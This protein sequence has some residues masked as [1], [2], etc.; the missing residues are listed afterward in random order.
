MQS[1]HPTET[2]N[3]DA[4]V[5]YVLAGSL[6]LI[7]A[8]LLV[9]VRDSTAAADIA[10]ALVLPVVAAAAAGGRLPGAAG[11]L[12]S[13]ATFDFFFTHPY[14]SLRITSRDDVETTV[15]L[16]AV[17]L[18][19]GTIAS[20]GRQ[21]R[22]ALTSERTDLDRIVRLAER[23]A[24]GDDIAEVLEDAA[25][26]ITEVLRLSECR[27][28]SPPFTE[29]LIRLERNGS[30]R[31]VRVHRFSRTGFELPPDGAALEVLSHGQPIGRFVLRPVAG[32]GSSLEE[33]VVAVAIADQAGAAL[34]G[35]ATK[36][37]AG[38]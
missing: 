2:R 15:L 26:Q 14:M 34:A 32:A 20:R 22:R 28:E 36:G 33:R 8:A 37:T 7:V 11:A 30:V 13:A 29:A 24:A 17:G 12:V 21:S 5:G 25:G 1:D 10:L 6:P 23:V 27:F 4:I 18:A 16:L 35:A 3:T 38:A 9:P 19:V 31:G